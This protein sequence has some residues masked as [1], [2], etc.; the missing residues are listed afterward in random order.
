M[1]RTPD[2]RFL[3]FKI[4]I[5]YIGLMTIG[6]GAIYAVEYNPNVSF[7]FYSEFGKQLLFS[8][9]SIFIGVLILFLDGKF[10]MKLS[11]LIYSLS[12][13]LLIG[14]LIFGQ[15]KYGARSWFNFGGI[16]D[17]KIDPDVW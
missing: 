10:L 14:V 2:F 4:I 12:I 11:Y 6:L 9:S 5:T 17:S 3:D 13:I 8:F 16:L 1:Y 15:E 7:S